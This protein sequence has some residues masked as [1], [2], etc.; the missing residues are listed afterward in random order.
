MAKFYVVFS[1]KFQISF[2]T[3][4]II[5]FLIKLPSFLFDC[6]ASWLV[7]H[8]H[9]NHPLCMS[10]PYFIIS[11]YTHQWAKKS[12]K[13]LN[14]K[15]HTRE[16]YLSSETCSVFLAGLLLIPAVSYGTESC[17]ILGY[18]GLSLY[19]TS[20]SRSLSPHLYVYIHLSFSVSCSTQPSYIYS[21]TLP[22]HSA[23]I[24]H[25][26]YWGRKLG[27]PVYVILHS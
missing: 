26:C 2:W 1:Y 11:R 17:A 15:W 23:S 6:I 7:S 12:Y 13:T 27:C 3:V 4:L 5:P 10:P 9:S 20:L 25:F 14:D 8:I 16:G 24:A 21:I 19:V 18:G 22:P